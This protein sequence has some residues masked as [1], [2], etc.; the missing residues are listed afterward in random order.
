MSPDIV[1]YN[2]LIDTCAR[3]GSGGL[4]SAI[5]VL[6]GMRESDM[7]PDIVTFNSLVNACARAAGL[8][9]S[10]AFSTAMQVCPCQRCLFG[11][12]LLGILDLCELGC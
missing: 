7:K 11:V 10:A 4:L 2:A 6:D 3:A 9:D 5:S 12:V 8:G 1:T